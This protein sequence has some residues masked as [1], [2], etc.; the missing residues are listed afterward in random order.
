MNTNSEYKITHRN[1]K[2]GSE[3]YTSVLKAET[4]NTDYLYMYNKSIQN[5]HMIMKSY[6]RSAATV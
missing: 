3:K 5:S 1:K 2:I 4:K 6:N